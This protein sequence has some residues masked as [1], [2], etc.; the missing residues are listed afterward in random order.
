MSP[1]NPTHNG[2]ETIAKTPADCIAARIRSFS[3]LR[4]SQWRKN[5]KGC[6]ISNNENPRTPP[7]DARSP[8]A[9]VSSNPT[10]MEIDADSDE[11]ILWKM[12]TYCSPGEKEDLQDSNVSEIGIGLF[13]YKF[14]EQVWHVNLHM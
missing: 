3:A 8:L 11:D 12:S 14:L 5:N 1:L 9:E 2:N 13:L 10:A 6:S 4:R 7:I